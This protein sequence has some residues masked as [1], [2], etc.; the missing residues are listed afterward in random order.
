MVKETIFT[1]K[2]REKKMGR[3]TICSHCGHVYDGHA[4]IY[5]KMCIY[6]GT[7]IET[8]IELRM[9]RENLDIKEKYRKIA[10]SKV[11]ERLTEEE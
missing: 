2:T 11:R 10:I 9:V 6:C 3:Q 5:G 8:E 7:F 4:N 1:Q